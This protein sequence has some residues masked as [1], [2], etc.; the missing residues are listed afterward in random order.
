MKKLLIAAAVSATLLAP[1]AAHAQKI[2][3][4]MAE[5]DTFLTIL[6]N[7]TVDAG[8]KA[9][10]TVQ[11]EDAGG[12]VLLVVALRQQRDHLGFGEDRAGAVDRAGRAGGAGHPSEMI[13]VGFQ[14]ARDAVQIG[15]RAKG[16]DTA[17]C[18]F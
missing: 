17:K 9:G 1:M 15:A 16:T 10:A 4:A 12:D 8:K 18:R 5:L 11:V 14:H 2:G 3:L 7:G 6:K 13:D